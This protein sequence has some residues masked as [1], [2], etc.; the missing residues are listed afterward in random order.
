M[1]N[2]EL[3]N[4]IRLFREKT[5]TNKL[6]VFVGAGVS[7]NVEGM[8]DWNDLIAKMA[9]SINY[10]KC[11][12]CKK[13]TRNCKK[14][15]KLYDVFSN[16][17]FLKIP[18]YVYNRNKK[19][20]DRVLSENIEHDRNI[21]A[22]LSNAIFDLTPAHIITTNYDKLIENC[23]NAQSD[24]YDVIVRDK[25]LLETQQNK[26]VIKMHGDIDDLSTIVLKE[27][28]YLEY[29]QNHI[30]IE[31][32]VKSLLTDHT[33]LF[34]GYSLNDYNIKLIISWINHIRAQNKALKKDTKFA[35]IV[36]DSEKVTSTQYKYFE[37]NY[38]GM[39][40]L[41]NM[42]LVD[43]IPI[44][45][46]NDVGK[47]LYSFLRIIESPLLEKHFANYMYFDEVVDFLKTY[48]YVNGKSIC[49]LL[50]LGRYSLSDYELVLFSESNYDLLINYINLK[51]EYS[52]SLEQLLYNAGVV[53]I[54]LI[55]S[56]GNRHNSYEISGYHITLL[57][58]PL[59]KLY[60]SNDYKKLDL[61][62]KN[63]S[64][65]NALEACFYKTIIQNYTTEVRTW[66][67]LIDYDGLCLADRVRY[68]FNEAAI[69]GIQKYNYSNEKVVK[70]IEGI[71]DKRIKKMFK[72][73]QDIFDGN[74]PKLYAEKEHFEKLKDQYYISKTSFIGC[75]SLQEF[76]KIQRIAYEQYL[77]YFNNT[78]IFKNFSDLKK[79]LKNYIEAI[80]CTNGRFV[81]ET[82][83][84]FGGK[85][86]KDRYR[87][88]IIDFD[89]ITKFM[90]IKDLHNTIEKYNLEKFEVSEEIVEHI[91]LCFEN[92]S[93][94]I[95]GL[96]LYHRFYE[97][98]NTFVNCMIMLTRLSLTEGQKAK[99]SNILYRLMKESKFVEFFF[100]DVFPEITISLKVLNCLLKQI[101]NWNDFEIVK[102]I[103]NNSNFK[104]YYINTSTQ[105][106]QEVL[107]S[108]IN[109]DA[110]IMLQDE[111]NSFILSFDGRDRINVIH[112]L[113]KHITRDNIKNEYRKFIA[114]N[115]DELRT[116]DIF[117]FVYHDMME[118]T[119]VEIDKILKDTL[120]IY[121]NQK[122]SGV[123]SV[124][125]PLS[126]N[127]ELVYILH[128]TGKID[129]L[130]M[131]NELINESDFLQFFIDS[132][133]F[134]YT[135]VDFSNYMWGNIVRH[136]IFMKKLVAHK[137]DI[138][139]KIQHR[140]EI[141]Q[142][143][144]L[145]KKLLYGY[146]LDQQEILDF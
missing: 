37:K 126:R 21:D 144:E 74:Y 61:E 40:N 89:I 92:L 18:Q 4:Y 10:S 136:D 128:I 94:S 41:R 34:L 124:P 33:I 16:D 67:K 32:F 52:K 28:D 6:I 145:E 107:A 63:I 27:A 130:D 121:R 36:V 85:S 43:D 17:E 103:I 138:I 127:L 84:S 101:P 110:R 64:K 116:T 5:Q 143:T 86:K 24:N 77:F 112:L 39:V 47:R 69:E 3:L 122:N 19:L 1:D 14:T 26:Y 141:E 111:I 100:S 54:R 104:S 106:L 79:I 73:Y 82:E 139:P 135:K 102:S 137:E 71:Y 38:I 132:E 59:F 68:L 9:E 146:F 7:K 15:C 88:S 123:R 81:E 76:Y 20:Y 80:I 12:S 13:K 2:I 66:I 109:V 57:D 46:K 117:E 98:P 91:I 140:L 45:L 75:S 108:F 35:Y 114:S 78:L 70:Y 125:D 95:V 120:T 118:I 99:I 44:A 134:D 142:A 11:S 50:C 58:N 60:I 133:N 56:S 119:D 30:L 23:S 105:R 29:T 97:A 72:P 129:S 62:L 22:P 83:D 55:P 48:K 31:M 115:F 113:Y 49:D 87:I 51:T 65:H 25:D 42:P 96:N 131:L 93:D 8:P 90:S 53:F